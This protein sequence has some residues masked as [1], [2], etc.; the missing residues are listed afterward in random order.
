MDYLPKKHTEAGLILEKAES[1]LDQLHSRWDKCVSKANSVFEFATG[2]LYVEQYFSESSRREVQKNK[3]VL[4][5]CIDHISHDRGSN[6][7]KTYNII[8]NKR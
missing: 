2:A 7:C 4:S 8:I 5:S 3:N 6:F 1:G